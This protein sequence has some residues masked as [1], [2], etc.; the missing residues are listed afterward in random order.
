MRPLPRGY[1]QQQLDVLALLSCLV[2]T[3]HAYLAWHQQPSAEFQEARDVFG[4]H[5]REKLDM[6]E[7]FAVLFGS[8]HALDERFDNLGGGVVELDLATTWN[9]PLRVS[10]V[11]LIWA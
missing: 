2:C 10:R 3:A 4:A 7:R 5:V 9:V 8:E 6:A 1:L 11:A